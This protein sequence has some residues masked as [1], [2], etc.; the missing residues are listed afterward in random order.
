VYVVEGSVM[1]VTLASRGDAPLAP[2]VMTV[3]GAGA[4]VT[5][6][7]LEPSRV[8]LIGGAPLD[9]PRHIW[10]NFVSSSEERME[11]AKLDWKSGRFPRVPGDDQEWIP[12]P[13]R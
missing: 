1:A 2:G 4:R 7:A 10:W 9:G 8:L 5:L 3:L 6:R 13:E 12:L 11:R